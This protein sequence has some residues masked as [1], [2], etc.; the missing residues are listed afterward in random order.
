MLASAC[1]C[2]GSGIWRNPRGSAFHT[3][4]GA[5]KGMLSTTPDLP[6]RGCP[7]ASHP[8]LELTA[9]WRHIKVDVVECETTPFG[10]LQRL[11]NP[12]NR[13]GKCLHQSGEG[14][15]KAIDELGA[16]V[17]GTH[18]RVSDSRSSAS[19]LRTFRVLPG[20][21]RYARIPICRPCAG[22]RFAGPR[23]GSR[24]A[25]SSASQGRGYAAVR[26]PALVS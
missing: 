14:A 23:F 25:H 26:R 5:A 4:S 21:R 2:S 6:E 12:S 22:D 24:P 1:L 19:V 17:G 7:R 9:L 15:M 8:R 16:T 18:G 13:A 11:R 10:R 20:C 3:R